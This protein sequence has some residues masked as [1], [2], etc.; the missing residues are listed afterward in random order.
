MNFAISGLPSGVS[1]TFSPDSIPANGG[2]Q[3]VTL[4]IGRTAFAPAPAL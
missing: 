2:L 1:A 4:T 3:T